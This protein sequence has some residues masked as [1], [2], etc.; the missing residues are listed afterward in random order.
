MSNRNTTRQSQ[1]VIDQTLATQLPLLM[2][3]A[4]VL[5]NKTRMTIGQIAPILLAHATA[6]G[7][8]NK[9]RQTAKTAKAAETALYAQ[10]KV[11]IA[12]VQI[13][14]AAL[15]GA[16]SDE[17]AALGFSPRKAAKT[18]VATRYV[19]TEKNKATRQARGTKG[20]NQK[21][22]IHGTVPAAEAP[23]ARK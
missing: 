1:L 23:A 14:A 9:A 16:D 8:T 15:F 7:A 13:A 22:T 20:K 5:V 6:I 18:S 2:A 3:T 12:A 19:A 11:I 4:T 10:V 21:K 17:Y